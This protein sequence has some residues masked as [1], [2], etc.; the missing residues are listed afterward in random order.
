[1]TV[2][3][4]PTWRRLLAD[5]VRDIG[6]EGDARRIVEEASG[7]EGADLVVHLD[8][9][10]TT[11]THA[12][13]A[14]M[15]ERRTAGEPLQY[16]LG[17]WGFRT[18]DL[19]VDKR[20]LIPRPETEMVV[21][22]ALAEVDRLDAATAVDLGT[23]SGAV[24][25][26]LAAERP[27]LTVWATDSS[28]AALDVA[29]ANLAGMGR[30]GARVRIVEGD[31]YDALPDELLGEVDV[32]VSNPPYVADGDPLPDEVAEWEPRDA[33]RSGPEGLDAIAVI[34]AGA[35]IWLRPGGSLVLEIGDT[36]GTRVVELAEKA[37]FRA[38]VRHDLARRD[39]ALVARLE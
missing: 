32:L 14:R 1:M 28:L 29:R 34:V 16:V 33:L 8:D 35:P 20:V 6:D 9:A 15:C 27:S 4:T 10:C 7:H 2:G 13:W 21:E 17:R 39:R 36:Q 37:G 38:D 11:L 31:W 3:D 24:A 18:L 30:A 25:L 12:H 19:L 5:A 23:G 22:H 26:S